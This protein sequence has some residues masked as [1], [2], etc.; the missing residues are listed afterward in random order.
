MNYIHCKTDACK[1]TY[2][3]SHFTCG[4]HVKGPHTQ[5]TCVAW[6]LPVKTDN[7][8]CFYLAST[9]RRIHAIARN[10]ALKLRATS[11]AGFI[12]TYLQ[13]AGEF[14]RDVIAGCLQLQ[15]ILCTI[16]CIFAC[17]CAD[18]FVC[19]CNCFC[20]RLA[21]LFTCDYSAF[22]IQLHVFFA[23]KSRQFCMLVAGKLA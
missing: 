20:L 21:D 8:T 5:F 3:C 6:S 19:V 18:I 12:L 10:K 22:C 11:P 23:I 7:Y 15:V 9:S 16:A 17:D 1:F 13:F 2:K 14:T 4:S